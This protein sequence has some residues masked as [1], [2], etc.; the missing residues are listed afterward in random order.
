MLVDFFFAIFSFKYLKFIVIAAVIPV[1]L[2]S[3]I[4][5]KIMF[6]LYGDEGDFQLRDF[7]S[8]VVVI[9]I[10]FF[11]QLLNEKFHLF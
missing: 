7:I 1:M 11:V 4:T 8:G 3:F 9:I 5:K 6:W 10:L 2:T